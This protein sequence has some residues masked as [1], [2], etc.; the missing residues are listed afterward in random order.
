MNAKSASSRSRSSVS[1]NM[2]KQGV[3]FMRY[4]AAG[5]KACIE[6]QINLIFLVEKNGDVKFVKDEISQPTPKCA[7]TDSP[8]GMHEF[9]LRNIHPIAFPLLPLLVRTSLIAARPLCI[10]RRVAFCRN[11]RVLRLVFRYW[12]LICFVVT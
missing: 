4:H 10:F 7:A 5:V 1:L 12:H 2:E 11:T 8:L 9:R 3:T 6:K